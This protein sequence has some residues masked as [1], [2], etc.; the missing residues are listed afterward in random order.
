MNATKS[1]LF[2]IFSAVLFLMLGPASL[3]LIG[4][5]I[6]QM[7]LRDSSTPRADA[8]HIGKPL[9]LSIIVPMSVAYISVNTI[10]L[11][12]L[13]KLFLSLTSLQLL[14]ITFSSAAIENADTDKKLYFALILNI[15]YYTSAFSITIYL[16]YYLRNFDKIRKS[17]EEIQVR[18]E[19]NSKSASF[20]GLL[21]LVSFV[22]ILNAFF[23]TDFLFSHRS[24]WISFRG[25][26]GI[27]LSSQLIL[28]TSIPAWLL[29]KRLA[30]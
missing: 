26:L 2:S 27:S 11:N 15:V 8:L 17:V 23:Y 9:L 10:P 4:L 28:L 13:K 21:L 25:I 30:S 1:I 29:I 14:N 12:E 6:V 18:N 24:G 20:L 5:L 22:F 3:M 19:K 16:S 7:C